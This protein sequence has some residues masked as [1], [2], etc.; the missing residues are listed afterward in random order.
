MTVKVVEESLKDLV[1]H[2]FL[3]LAQ[4]IFILIV[5]G[6]L[7]VFLLQSFRRRRQRAV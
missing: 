1:D 3:R 2:V 7:L 5:V 6:G 4:G